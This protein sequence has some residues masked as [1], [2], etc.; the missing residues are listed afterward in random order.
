MDPDVDPLQILPAEHLR[1]MGDDA[2]RQ[3]TQSCAPRR[4][5]DDD[6]DGPALDRRDPE[7]FRTGHVEVAFEV[8]LTTP[9]LVR[10]P[11][12][13]SEDGRIIGDDRADRLPWA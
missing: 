8:L 7:S 4:G 12:Q 11:R 3:E 13:C 6:D 2:R 9:E 10:P 1:G 5:V